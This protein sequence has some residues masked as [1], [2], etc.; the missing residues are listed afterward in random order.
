MIS[1]LVRETLRAATPPVLWQAARTVISTVI[2][3]V[4]DQ[5]RER[6]GLNGLDSILEPH[7]ETSRQ[8]YFVELGANDGLDQSNTYFLEREFG[9]RGLLV[10][11]SLNRYLEL[12][13]NR[14]EG[15]AFACAACV[16]FDYDGEFVR[17]TYA[18][19]MTIS[20]SLPSDLGDSSAHIASG[21]RFLASKAEVVDFGAV[22]R[23]L[24]ALL[25]EASAP[26]RIDLLSLDVEG[27]EIA[28]LRGV[29]HA[30]YR[31]DR[32]LIES[33]SIDTLVNYLAE[34]GYR[35]RAQLS[36]HDFLFEDASDGGT[37]PSRSSA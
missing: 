26:R 20:R 22:A 33:R 24:D 16:P 15:N 10:E 11:P 35:L 27:A 29:N 1:R 34:H 19:L 36:H 18:N 3:P 31:F 32:L 8:G 12:I 4:S 37:Q 13:R 28:V 7:L 2:T 5:G 21:I 23:T 14:H 30:K 9:W 17:L 25:D 6:L